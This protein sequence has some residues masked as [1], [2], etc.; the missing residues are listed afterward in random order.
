VC[1][2]ECVSLRT[3]VTWC[4]HSVGSMAA[5]SPFHALST[6]WSIKTRHS[7]S[8]H[9]YTHTHTAILKLLLFSRHSTPVVR[10]GSLRRV[11]NS[12]IRLKLIEPYAQLHCQT[13]THTHGIHEAEMDRDRDR[14]RNTPKHQKHIDQR[15]RLLMEA[16]NQLSFWL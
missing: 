16:N 4:S 7:T 1:V 9:P 8:T 12:N 5:V 11:G 2:W 13:H 15:D 6:I 3:S 10:S 14:N